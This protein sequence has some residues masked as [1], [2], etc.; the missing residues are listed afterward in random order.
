[1]AT[2]KPILIAADHAGVELKAALQKLLSNHK[3][4]DLGPAATSPS[5]DYPDYA[6][7]LARLVASGDRLGILI[8][9]SG[10]G[11]SIA[12]NKIPGVRAALVEN[13][14]SARL[15]REHNEA[16]VLCLGARFVAPHYAAEII[17]AWLEA[18]PSTD[19][20]HLNRVKKLNSLC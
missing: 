20:R 6:E 3:W 12:A 17:R 18:A 11:M 2:S 14:V 9:G 15:A 7:K 1:M 16:N 5:V 13:P 10:I 8:C 19:E 4:E